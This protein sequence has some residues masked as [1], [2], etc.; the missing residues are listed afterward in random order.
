MAKEQCDL[1]GGDL[2]EAL[3]RYNSHFDPLPKARR[4]SLLSRLKQRLKSS[5]PK[6]K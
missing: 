3:T 4:E 6:N 1:T 5:L 2:I